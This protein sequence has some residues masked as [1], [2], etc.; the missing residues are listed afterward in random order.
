[1]PGVYCQNWSFEHDQ[2]RLDNPEDLQ[3]RFAAHGAAKSSYDSLWNLLKQVIV[4]SCEIPV[5]RV[6]SGG[7]RSH[8]YAT[9]GFGLGEAKL[10]VD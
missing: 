4:T 9:A 8:G 1:M 2:V 3:T 7:K 6:D 10:T 5:R